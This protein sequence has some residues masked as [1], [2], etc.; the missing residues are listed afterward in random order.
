MKIVNR[1]IKPSPLCKIPN[2]R[3]NRIDLA[4]FRRRHQRI[5]QIILLQIHKRRLR[6]LVQ[7]HIAK[8]PQ[9]I[10]R[11]HLGEQLPIID[12]VRDVLLLDLLHVVE[13]LV[14][15]VF[16]EDPG[17]R[18]FLQLPDPEDAPDGLVFGAAV[19]PQV[20][21]DHA[22]GFGEVDWM[23]FVS[24]FGGEGSDG[25]TDGRCYRSGETLP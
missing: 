18:G 19:E 17:E 15:R 14:D 16:D 7:A 13:A 6:R 21:E 23:Y 9:H 2:Q 11:R 22:G 3:N 10:Q 20:H 12:G 24:R 4:L 25:G 8:E 5:D 1:T